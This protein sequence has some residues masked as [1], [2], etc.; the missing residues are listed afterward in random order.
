M[1]RA[2]WVRDRLSVDRGDRAEGGIEGTDGQLCGAQLGGLRGLQGLP[3]L[4]R[5]RDERDDEQ[6]EER[7]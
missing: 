4:R 3:L 7:A 1:L 6:D 2:G 5:A